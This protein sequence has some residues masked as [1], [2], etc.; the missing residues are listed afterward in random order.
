[1]LHINT[2]R[3]ELFPRLQLEK[4]RHKEKEFSLSLPPTTMKDLNSQPTILFKSPL[5][6]KSYM[7]TEDLG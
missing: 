2:V 7:A 1:M 5:F 4:I 6:I 3:Q